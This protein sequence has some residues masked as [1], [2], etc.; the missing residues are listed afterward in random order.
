MKVIE[1][2]DK[3]LPKIKKLNFDVLAITGDHSTPSKMKGHSW[4]PV[5][6]I[7]KSDNS[8]EG[9]SKRFTEKECLKG[10]MG[11][12]EGKYLLNLIFAHG[13]MLNKFGA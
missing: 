7:I 10:N 6:V 5:P 3:V 12:F 4:H 8:F 2:F 11:I 1:E 9:I 13:Q